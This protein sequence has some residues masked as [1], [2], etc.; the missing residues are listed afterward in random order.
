MKKARGKR[1]SALA[2]A[3]AKLD[4]F[5]PRAQQVIRQTRARVIHGVPNSDG[6]LLSI[7]EPQARILR[8]GKLHKPTE[9]GSLVKVQE[10]E[11]GI[12]TDLDVV[13]THHD[14]ALLVPSV[15]RHIE[16]FGAP[17][18]L[19]STDRGFYSGAGIQRIEELGVRRAVIPFPGKKSQ[20][21]LRHERQ[22]WCPWRARH[23]R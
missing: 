1:R 21:R 13:S 7:F 17:P 3:V 11:G 6:K 16:I 14:A 4:V 20:R 15:E 9:F 10:A 23:F 2:R 5:V 19:A 12:V 22:R 18:V 8:R